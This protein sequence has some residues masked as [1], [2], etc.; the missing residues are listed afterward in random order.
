[1]E[2][3]HSFQEF[4]ADNYSDENNLIP[5]TRGSSGIDKRKLRQLRIEYI[6][7]KNADGTYNLYKS[8]EEAD[9]NMKEIDIKVWDI[10]SRTGEN[11]KNIKINS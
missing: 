9:A 3:E 6:F 7:G 11:Y 5:A 10:D 2:D 8:K 1:M 4:L